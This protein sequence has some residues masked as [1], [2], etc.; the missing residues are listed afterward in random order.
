ML[1]ELDA[2]VLLHDVRDKVY[3]QGKKLGRLISSENF[4]DFLTAVYR[5]GQAAIV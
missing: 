3:P 4:I 2:K 1:T 5:I